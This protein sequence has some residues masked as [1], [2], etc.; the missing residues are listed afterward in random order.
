MCLRGLRE[1]G[2]GGGLRVLGVLRR[3]RLLRLLRLLRRGYRLHGLRGFG[4]AR[5]D[6]LG[7]LRVGRAHGLRGLGIASRIT[8]LRGRLACLRGRLARSG[9]GLTGLARLAGLWGQRGD[10]LRRVAVTTLVLGWLLGLRLR[11]LLRSL[12][13]PGLLRSL[14]GL[15]TLRILGRLL[16]SLLGLLRRGLLLGRVRLPGLL[17]LGRLLRLARLSGRLARC[18]IRSLGLCSC[19]FV[20]MRDG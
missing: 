18:L 14:L 6:G 13:L 20:T 9:R 16:R 10:D 15:L 5:A 8:R 4:I 2:G 7:R 17:R 3:L 12:G 19:G 11:R 1:P